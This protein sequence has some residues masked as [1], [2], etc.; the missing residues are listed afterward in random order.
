VVPLMAIEKVPWSRLSVHVTQR[1]ATPR[2]QNGGTFTWPVSPAHT[3]HDWLERERER[4][5]KH[6]PNMS[7]YAYPCGR[8]TFG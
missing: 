2:G 3:R 1:T 7:S 6:E 5:V 8:G 4:E